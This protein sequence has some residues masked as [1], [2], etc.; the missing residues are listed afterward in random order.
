MTDTDNAAPDWRRH[1]PI[2][3]VRPVLPGWPDDPLRERQVVGC[4]GCGWRST[5]QAHGSHGFGDHLRRF[6][7]PD[8]MIGYWL[9]WA[10]IVEVSRGVLDREA[11]AAELADYRSVADG[12]TAVYDELAGLSKPDTAPHH[13]VEFAER[14]FA[15]RYADLLCDAAY[16]HMQDCDTAGFAALVAVAEMWEPGSWDAYLSDLDLHHELAEKRTNNV[17]SP[18]ENGMMVERVDHERAA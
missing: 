15:A 18:T 4:T 7:A 11:V 2:Y 12:A 14:R 17:T 10:D 3:A 16:G 1:E 5:E 6:G 9:D 13:V 8:H